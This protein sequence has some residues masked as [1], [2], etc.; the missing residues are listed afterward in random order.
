[1]K[2]KLRW[3]LIGLP[4]QGVIVLVLMIVFT[5]STIGFPA[6]WLVREQLDRQ[7]W[8]SVNQ[9]SRMVE[10][11]LDAHHRDLSNLAILTSQRPTL[12]Q[13]LDSDDSTRLSD[14]LE[15][16]RKGAG[17]DLI[18]ICQQSRKT[19]SQVGLPISNLACQSEPTDQVFLSTIDTT[20]TIWLLSIHP[21]LDQPSDHV[22]VGQILDRDFLGEL[23]EQTGVEILI[24]YQGQLVGGSFPDNNLVWDTISSQ[25][26][27]PGDGTANNSRSDHLFLQEANYYTIRSR[28]NG[29]EMETIVFLPGSLIIETQQRLTSRLAGGIL[30]VTIVCLVLAII[31]AKRVS[32][33]LER[34]RSSAIAFRKGDLITPVSTNSKVREIAQ[35]SY[36]LEDARIALRHTLEELRMEKAWGDYMLESVVEGIITLDRQNRITLFSRGAER[37]TGFTQE[38]VVGKNIDEVFQLAERNSLFS[39]H[40]PLQG[41]KQEIVTILVHQKPL[42]LALHG[43]QLV[44][45]EA[46]K[47]QLTLSIRDI[48][49]EEAMRGLLG[50]FILN[51]THEFRTP[52]T[53]LAVSIELLLDQLPDLS[54]AEL[55]ELLVSNH[56]GVL[57]L[58]NLIDNLLEAASI[59]AGRFQ[60]YPRPIELANVIHE[61]SDMMHPLIEKNRHQFVL[62]IPPDLPLVM[63]DPRRTSQVLVNLL[64][65]A[66]K[67][68]PQ[69]SEIRLSVSALLH[70]IKV[71]VAD[72]GP[73]ILPEQKPNLFV[74]FQQAQ[75]GRSEFGAGLGLSV[76]KAI[77]E[78]QNGQVGVEE[79]PGGGA[80]FWFTIPVVELE[81]T[82][83][84]H[85]L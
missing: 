36:A 9:A 37:I 75:N 74:R 25:Q 76:V 39:Q 58:Q 80:V 30:L 50:D 28:F 35:V 56:L 61:V 22:A 10:V 15:T 26:E 29:T 46:G 2:S 53:A 71:C 81:G 45:P 38:Q 8:V 6:I 77:V 47:A 4:A 17:L 3:H 73:G 64:S 11:L 48:S 23:S 27:E 24:L 85:N 78:S 72:Q 34:L 20:S 65:N 1:M 41:E 5:S 43:T 82:E 68:G 59:E 7:A 16:I 49:N 54:Q 84:D 51:I 31:L 42:T 79:R 69:G 62:D 55:H 83:E 60:V 70:E 57:S 52:L 44:P 33:P 66:I 32:Q 18:L 21:L 63:A 19:V 40:L 67:W 13:L 12:R 14:Y